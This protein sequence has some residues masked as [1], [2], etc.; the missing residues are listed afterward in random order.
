MPATHNLAI[1]VLVAIFCHIEL[2][3]TVK[4]QML[5][6]WKIKLKNINSVATVVRLHGEESAWG[7]ISGFPMNG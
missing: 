2:N 7:Q 1:S 4:Y 3:E 5:G 6:K